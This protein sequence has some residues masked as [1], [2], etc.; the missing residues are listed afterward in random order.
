MEKY[1]KIQSKCLNGSPG[2]IVTDI[3]WPV[4]SF[5]E[6]LLKA[7]GV[8]EKC[9]EKEVPLAKDVVV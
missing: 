7:C 6:V 8:E 3:I 5:G 2:H 4:N 1:N 9:E